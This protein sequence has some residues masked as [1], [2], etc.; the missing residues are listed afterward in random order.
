MARDAP[1]GILVGVVALIPL[2]GANQESGESAALWV[3]PELTDP[4]GAVDVGEHQDVQLGAASGTEGIE[5]FTE[6]P[7]DLVQVLGDGS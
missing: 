6:L 4:F 3:T 5:P 7:V 2:F 1:L